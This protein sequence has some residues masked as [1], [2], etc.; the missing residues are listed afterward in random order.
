MFVA[1]CAKEMRKQKPAVCQSMLTRDL[2]SVSAVV[3]SPH[4]PIDVTSDVQQQKV[5]NSS[6]RAHFC[7]SWCQCFW[8][9][10]HWD[11]FHQEY[12]YNCCSGMTHFMAHFLVFSATYELFTLIL[13]SST[14]FSN[15]LCS[16]C[17]LFI[18]TSSSW[19]GSLVSITTN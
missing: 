16:Y 14:I 2:S 5:N 11:I 7:L 19:Q 13:S 17:S 15:L 4:T 10:N 3:M 8:S 6:L 1:S 18:H 9:I 12:C